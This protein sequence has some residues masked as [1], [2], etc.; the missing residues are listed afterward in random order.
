L[1][2]PRR[3]DDVIAC[4]NATG[5][6]GEFIP[7]ALKGRDKYSAPSGLAIIIYDLFS[8]G[9]APGYYIVAPSGLSETFRTAS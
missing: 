5:R 4:G 2:K 1:E 3:G 7:Q 9:D 6:E 8:W